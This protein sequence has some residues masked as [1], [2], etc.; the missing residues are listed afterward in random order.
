MHLPLKMERKKLSRHLEIFS[1]FQGCEKVGVKER[2]QA[3]K[4]VLAQETPILFLLRENS[5]DPNP[6]QGHYM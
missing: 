4:S 5:L 1:K 3:S 2:C 6:N